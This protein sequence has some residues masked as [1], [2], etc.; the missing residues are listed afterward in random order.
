ML[1]LLNLDS[2]GPAISDIG[3]V[4]VHSSCD[5][6]SDLF[7]T[8]EG[9]VNQSSFHTSNNEDTIVGRLLKFSY[10][11]G[12][13]ITSENAYLYQDKLMEFIENEDCD[14]LEELQQIT[15]PY[16]ICKL[17]NIQPYS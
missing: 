4:E 7:E 14:H 8:T 16:F 6:I 15:V 10:E 12:V 9:D 1:S 11:E 17:F 13:S 3:S 2:S 5:E